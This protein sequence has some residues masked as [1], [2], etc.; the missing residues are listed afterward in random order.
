I[1]KT[2]R[3]VIGEY[4][5]K[6]QAIGYD[7]HNADGIL[8][9]LEEICPVLVEVRQSTKVLGSATEAFQLD[10]KSKQVVTDRKNDLLAWSVVNAK[11]IRNAYNEMKIDKL[12]RNQ[13][14]DPVDAVINAI[15]VKQKLSTTEPRDNNAEIDAYLKAMGWD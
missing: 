14:I 10:I 12:K 7:P 8:S 15:T 13:R 6:P 5:L 4:D 2:L 3:D 1:I 11:Y 9:D